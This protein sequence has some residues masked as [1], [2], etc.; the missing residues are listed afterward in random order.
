MN[1]AKGFRNHPRVQ[2]SAVLRKAAT[3][4]MEPKLMLQRRQVRRSDFA[5][6]PPI[7]VNSLPKSG[8][9]LLLQIARAMPGSHYYGRFVATAPSVSLKQRSPDALARRIRRFMPGETAGAHLHY[10]PEVAHALEEINALHLF[11]YRDPRDVII[12]EVHYLTDMNRWHRMHKHFRGLPDSH[13]RLALALN[14]LDLRYPEANA[15][16]LPYAGW[17]DAPSV[18]AIRY[19]DLI[20]PRQGDEIARIVAAWQARGG[21]IETDELERRLRESIDPKRSHTFREGGS[22][23]W[24]R[25]LTNTEA[26][27]ITE[28]LKPA[29][30]AYGYAL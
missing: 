27:R 21:A 29:L 26:D 12:S 23:K 9:H 10:L 13:A 5:S 4:A 7:V 30:T 11:I 1:T 24:R 28:Y 25:G 15:R 20:G 22:G 3:F 18:I 6:A 14:G 19:E 16:M 2:R 8:T 17:V